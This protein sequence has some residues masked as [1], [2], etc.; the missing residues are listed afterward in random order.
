MPEA[1]PLVDRD[2]IDLHLFE[3]AGGSG[4]QDRAARMAGPGG[5]VCAEGLLGFRAYRRRASSDPT[6]AQRILAGLLD[7]ETPR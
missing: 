2:D 6:E 1:V 7:E 4:D 3:L 5:V